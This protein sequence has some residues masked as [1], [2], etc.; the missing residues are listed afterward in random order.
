MGVGKKKKKKDDFRDKIVHIADSPIDERSWHIVHCDFGPVLLCVWYRP[1]VRG[2][3]ESIRRFAAELDLY[4]QDSVAVLAVGDLNVHNAEWFR[5]SDGT[6]PE[7]R[8]NMSATS[9]V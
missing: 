9:V 3:I 2:E 5:F 8:W 1:P 7:G 6:S 4:M